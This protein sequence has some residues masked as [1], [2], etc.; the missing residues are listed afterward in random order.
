MRLTLVVENGRW[1]MSVVDEGGGDP[2]ALLRVLANP[3]PP[4]LED[5]RGRGLFLL[6]EMVDSLQV[7]RSPDGR[8]LCVTAIRKHAG[9]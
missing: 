9:R 6:R 8:G 3:D 7:A 1:T 2:D 5:E 4:D